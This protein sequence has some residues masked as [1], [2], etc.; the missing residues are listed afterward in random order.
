MTNRPSLNTEGNYVA[1]LAAVA[2]FVVLAVV[3]LTA[4]F[5]APAGFPDGAVIT[6][7]LGA[8]M[9][10]IAPGQL[11]GEGEAAVPGEGFL[12]AFEIIDVLLVAALVGAVMLARREEAGEIVGLGSGTGEPDDAVAADGG[13]VDGGDD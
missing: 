11:M 8:A 13:E 7:S 5:P 10:D 2:L 4:A 1:G 9:F 6:K 12:V 3:F